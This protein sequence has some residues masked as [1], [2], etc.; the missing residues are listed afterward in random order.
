MSINVTQ[1]NFK[2]VG[3]TVNG[4]C[5]GGGTLVQ[6]NNVIGGR[7]RGE[8]VK[9]SSGVYIFSRSDDGR[10]EEEEDEEEDEGEHEGSI[11]VNGVDLV[12]EFHKQQQSLNSLKEQVKALNDKVDK[13][14]SLDKT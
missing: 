4:I 6:S 10:K 8:W 11:I 5:I 7:R 3:G 9:N 13:L 14:V 1:K 2:A 12:K